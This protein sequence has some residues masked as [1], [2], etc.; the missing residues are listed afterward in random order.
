MKIT[1]L[2]GLVFGGLLLAGCLEGESESDP[3][4]VESDVEESNDT[5]TMLRYGVEKKRFVE[6]R[7]TSDDP[8]RWQR[9]TVHLGN[10]YWLAGRGPD[11]DAEPVA[12]LRRDPVEAAQLA[13]CP[14]DV[15]VD[16][17]RSGHRRLDL[18][19]DP[20]GEAQRGAEA[21]VDAA[22]GEH[23]GGRP[24]LGLAAGTLGGN[25]Y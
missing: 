8:V 10:A 21:A 4:S 2:L 25:P 13:A 22:S 23:A 3:T 20:A 17:D 15:D 9:D 6:A 12:V 11:G 14:A 5:P 16:L 19:V 1:G 18:G 7:R 24:Y